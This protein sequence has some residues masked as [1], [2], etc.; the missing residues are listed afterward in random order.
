[1]VKENKIEQI[2]FWLLIIGGANWGLIGLFDF[3]LV[4]A[5]FGDGWFSRTIYSVVGIST[6]IVGYF[7]LT[8]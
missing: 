4:S 7:R 2:A 3:N 6:G 1:M 8:K 5:I